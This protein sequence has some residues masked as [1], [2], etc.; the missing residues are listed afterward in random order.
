MV[1]MSD[2]DPDDDHMQWL[3]AERGAENNSSEGFSS[4]KERHEE[5]LYLVPELIARRYR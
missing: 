5:A 1:T 4:S 3:H 2:D